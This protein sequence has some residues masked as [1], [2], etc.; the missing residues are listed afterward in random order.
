MFQIE[1]LQ[2]I[3]IHILYSIMIFRKSCRLRDNLGK[4]G[5]A[6]KATDDY[7]TANSRY[8]LDN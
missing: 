4:Y 2:Q 1:V 7:D 5:T 8:M 3:K 6:S